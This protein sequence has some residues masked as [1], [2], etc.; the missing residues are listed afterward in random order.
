MSSVFAS[1]PFE[2]H[3]ARI[4][5]NVQRLL[6][7]ARASPP[8][9]RDIVDGYEAKRQLAMC[10]QYL[11]DVQVRLA[12][13]TTSVRLPTNLKDTCQRS[14]LERELSRLLRPHM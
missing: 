14:L 4:F 5:A 9:I 12:P 8:V 1:E 7:E 2:N 3:T 6:Q 11:N 10:N 13:I